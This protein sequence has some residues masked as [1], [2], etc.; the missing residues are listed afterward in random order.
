MS[1]ASEIW[2]FYNI[3]RTKEYEYLDLS[4][5]FSFLPLKE[6]TTPGISGGRLYP[7]TFTTAPQC[8]SAQAQQNRRIQSVH[9]HAFVIP[10]YINCQAALTRFRL[11]RSTLC[12]VCQRSYC[13]C[14][15][16]HPSA[17]R[18]KTF[19]SLRAISG[20]I[21]ERPL[22]NADKVFLVT[23]SAFAASVTVMPRGSIQ[24]SLIISPG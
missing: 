10:V 9:L 4:I 21:P 2:G 16:S 3:Q 17:E 18:P 5:Q 19:E 8:E 23:P 15:L 1:T 24:N 11:S 7:K 14:S 12:C 6:D 20:L 13:N 22:S